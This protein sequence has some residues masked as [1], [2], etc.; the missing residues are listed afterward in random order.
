MLSSCPTLATITSTGTD[1]AGSR[2]YWRAESRRC[3]SDWVSLLDAT[4]QALRHLRTRHAAG[5]SS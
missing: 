1:P 4:D 3:G 2:E 5:V